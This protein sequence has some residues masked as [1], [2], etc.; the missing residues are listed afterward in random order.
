MKYQYEIKKININNEEF[1]DELFNG[2]DGI[3][4]IKITEK[5]EKELNI[6][7]LETLKNNHYSSNEKKRRSAT[8]TFKWLQE[9]YPELLI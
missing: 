9:N 3:S 4:D 7:W 8:R 5:S 2:W 1:F 6:F